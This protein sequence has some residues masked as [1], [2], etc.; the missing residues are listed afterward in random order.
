MNISTK[1]MEAL[2]SGLNIC[3]DKKLPIK[4]Y[5]LKCGNE[6]IKAYCNQWWSTFGGY[7]SSLKIM[8]N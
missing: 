4:E 2:K 6:T 3:I 1:Q 8:S 7:K 5:N